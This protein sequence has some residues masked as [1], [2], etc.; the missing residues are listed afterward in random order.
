MRKRNYI[1][2]LIVLVMLA[3]IFTSCIQSDAFPFIENG[4]DFRT[5]RDSYEPDN[6]PE[7]AK[8]IRVGETQNRALESE[9]WAYIVLNSRSSIELKTQNLD[10]AD[11]VMY[12][13]DRSLRLLDSDDDGAE[14]RLASKIEMELNSGSYYVRIV[15]YGQTTEQRDS[16]LKPRGSYSENHSYQLHYEA[17][18]GGI[19]TGTISGRIRDANT[20]AGIREAVVVCGSVE[21]QSDNNGDYELR[22]VEYG[23]RT[24]IVNKNGY[25]RKSE[26]ITVNGNET[27]N[28]NMSRS[29]SGDDYEPDDSPEGAHEIRNRETQNRV[30]ESEDWAYIVLNS[31]SN[32]E[33]KTQNL[34]GADTVMYL[35]DRSLRLLDSDDD[36]AEES[37]A[38][39]IEMELNSGRYYVRIVEYGQT[40]EQR[41]SGLKPRGSYSENHSYQL[42][43]E[44]NTGSDPDPDSGDGYR[45]LIIG[46]SE[47]AGAA[48]LI[49]CEYDAE[50]VRD[51]FRHWNQDFDEIE[52]LTGNVTKNEII[53]KLDEFIAVNTERD[54][55]FYFYFAGH[56]GENSSHESYL[57]CSDGQAITV[58]ELRRKLDRIDGTKVVIIDACHSSDFTNLSSARVDEEQAVKSFN[59][60][61]ID[62]FQ[63][64]ETQSRGSYVTDSEYYVMTGCRLNESSGC[65]NNYG[66]F[67]MN[68]LNGLG[69]GSN[70][71]HFN[72]TYDAD[73]YLS[74]SSS[75]RRIEFLESY[76]YAKDNLDSNRQHIQAS[77]IGSYGMNFVMT[78]F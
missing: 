52:M 58:S 74:N 26:T 56:G 65:N 13:Y 61:M 6:T 44:T 76:Y 72:S 2:V 39:K 36:G 5:V 57:Y 10:G 17:G 9:D 54:D 77:P 1:V 16:G 66:Y 47:N 12:L 4:V 34:D 15:E 19:E 53:R 43:Y 45:A 70:N 24:I 62:G 35:Y 22:N 68:L 67:T 32:I 20:G 51:T 28:I 41:D 7:Q 23:Q 71:Y 33:L 69:N 64:S 21:V 8:Q 30:L 14:E 46:I 29:G 25:A 40:T 49:S 78:S 3:G 48:N 73:G 59:N 27:L 75:N 18:N 63:S 37:L 55:V 38:S 11:T 50:A 42:Y 31:R 60:K